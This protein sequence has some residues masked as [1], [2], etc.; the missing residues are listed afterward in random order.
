MKSGKTF[1]RDDLV[2][3][4]YEALETGL[5]NSGK[6][7]IDKLANDDK[8]VFKPAATALGILTSDLEAEYGNI[9]SY[10]PASSS[11]G[12]V[13]KN[14]TE[15]FK[16][17]RKSVYTFQSQVRIDL[18]SYS[19]DLFSDFEST[20]DRAVSAVTKSTG[21]ENILSEWAYSSTGNSF[22]LSL[23]YWDSKKEFDA[24]KLQ[25]AQALYKARYIVAAR[26]K[27]SM[28][29]YNKELVLHD[30]IVNTTKYDYENYKKG[31]VPD[32][33]FTAYGCLNLGTA[34]CQGYSNAMKL[35]SDLSGLEC[36][37]V[38]GKSSSGSTWE[39]H[40]WN[41]VKVAGNYYHLDVTF[42]DPVVADSKGLL[43]HYYFNLSDKELSRKHRWDASA[44][45]DCNST[46]E[47]FYTKNGMVAANISEL[48]T[49]LLSAVQ[50]RKTEVEIRVSNYS[51]AAYDGFTD[52]L[53]RNSAVEGFYY[54]VNDEFGVIRLFD[55][56]YS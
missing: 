6:T 35:L 12:Y 29:D 11:N 56:R 50:N 7:L 18:S 8:T 33:S 45:P 1:L 44:Y 37:V 47:N 13:V 48:N 17:L 52:V 39:G 32:V 10:A 38:A 25:N 49:A 20:C 9:E 27:P 5:H 24:K 55:I 2:G 14:N 34:V 36:L 28:S 26:I 21:V 46:A 31:S 22:T 30:Y 54:V 51:E 16:L 42:D 53:Y 15:L 4:S 43:T 40:A 3:V 41:M 19:G 23:S